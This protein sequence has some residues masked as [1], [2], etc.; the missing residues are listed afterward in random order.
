MLDKLK[1]EKEKLQKLIDLANTPDEEIEKMS[2]KDK[3]KVFKAKNQLCH[4]CW[5]SSKGTYIK[6]KPKEQVIKNKSEYYGG[7]IKEGEENETSNK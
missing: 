6:P 1:D 5:D 4:K 2:F 3:Q 7:E